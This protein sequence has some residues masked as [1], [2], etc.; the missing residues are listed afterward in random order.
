MEESFRAA[1]ALQTEQWEVAG[2]NSP[3]VYGESVGIP[4][5]LGPVRG[6]RTQTERPG[7]RHQIHLLVVQHRGWDL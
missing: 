3:E 5:I 2:D 6:K 1:D 4:L 7:Q